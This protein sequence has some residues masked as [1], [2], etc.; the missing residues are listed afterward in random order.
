MIHSLEKS[1]MRIRLQTFQID[2]LISPSDWLLEPSWNRFVVGEFERSTIG[3]YFWKVSGR[4]GFTDF[5]LNLRINRIIGWR[6]FRPVVSSSVVLSQH[7]SLGMICVHRAQHDDHGAPPS[8]FAIRFKPRARTTTRSPP[9]YRST[10]HLYF[11]LKTLTLQT[12]SRDNF[13]RDY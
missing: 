13:D 7:L 1:C 8:S 12:V 10:K 5:T 3:K 2:A 4:V 11:L 6:I 9:R